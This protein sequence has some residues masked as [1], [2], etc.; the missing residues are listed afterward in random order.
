MSY[1]WWH[2]WLSFF[3]LDYETHYFADL[4]I[5]FISFFLVVNIIFCLTSVETICFIKDELL[6]MA[7]SFSFSDVNDMRNKFMEKSSEWS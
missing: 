1:L 6:F 7:H 4:Q 2:I 3:A 5:P